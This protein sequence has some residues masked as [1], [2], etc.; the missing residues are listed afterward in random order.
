MSGRVVTLGETM[1]LVRCTDGRLE[2]SSVVALSVGGAESNV[3]IGV[4]R[5]GGSAAWLGRVGDDGLGR[6]V[7]REIRAEGVRV[8]AL[9]DPN[10]PTGLMIKEARTP[11]S[12]AVSYYRASSAGSRLSP[13]D[14]H[15][16]VIAESAVLHVTGITPAL[17]ASAAEAVN[18]AITIAEE[19]GVPVSFDVNHRASLWAGRDPGPVYRRIAAR[20]TIVF[21]GD[22]EAS[23]LVGAGP[24]TDQAHRLAELGPTQVVVKL[25]SRGCV[26]YVDGVD[27]TVPAIEVPVVDTVGAGDAFVAG[28]LTS[29]TDGGTVLER[30]DLGTRCGAFAC[31]NAGDWESAPTR[32]D[33]SLLDTARD[34]VIR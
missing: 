5:L 12:T 21:A 26:A 16:T 29:L 8:H 34:P 10:A 18:A 4:A 31:L 19:A 27:H 11:R 24:P 22:D 2:H 1:G 7:L 33:L 17:S 15:P 32:R 23:L 9:V 25:G 3:A 6:R 20:S 28:Y 14:L 13:A 30:L